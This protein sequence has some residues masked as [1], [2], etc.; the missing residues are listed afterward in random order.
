MGD[1][2]LERLRGLVDQEQMPIRLA[3]INVGQA[4]GELESAMKKLDVIEKRLKGRQKKL[5]TG[6]AELMEMR[7]DPIVLVRNYGARRNIYHS[8]DHPCGWVGDRHGYDRVLWGAARA[9]GKH[10]CTACGYRADHAAK[11]ARPKPDEEDGR[12]RIA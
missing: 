4:K 3:L 1:E 10:P 8:A 6:M 7:N 2:W 9:E 11:K 12:R 5:Q